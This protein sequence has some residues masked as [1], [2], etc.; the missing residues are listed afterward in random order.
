MRGPVGMSTVFL[1]LEF[2]VRAGLLWALNEPF[3]IGLL[4]LKSGS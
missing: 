2:G 4:A 3:P 1:S